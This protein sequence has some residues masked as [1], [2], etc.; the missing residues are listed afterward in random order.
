MLSGRGHVDARAVVTS[1]APKSTA[2]GRAAAAS[3]GGGGDRG[4]RS[5]G[6]VARAGGRGRKKSAYQLLDDLGV[7]HERPAGGACG[8]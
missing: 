3:D 4:G 8:G 5:G 7:L 1:D 2:S 6:R